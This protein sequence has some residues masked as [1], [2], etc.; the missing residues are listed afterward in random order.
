MSSRI[1]STNSAF[2]TWDGQ[3]PQSKLD[4]LRL[5]DDLVMMVKEGRHLDETEQQKAVCLLK[6]VTP[7]DHHP[8]RN[9]TSQLPTTDDDA[10]KTLLDSISILLTCSSRQVVYAAIS[11]LDEWIRWFPIEVR[12]WFV[13]TDQHIHLMNVLQPH[14]VTFE[15]NHS[16]HNALVSIMTRLLFFGATGGILHRSSVIQES[17]STICEIVFNKVLVPSQTYLRFLCQQRISHLSVEFVGRMLDLPIP[18]F[19]VGV[20]YPPAFT[21]LLSTSIFHF[22]T[23]NLFEFE[24]ERWIDYWVKKLQRF[25]LQWK[26]ENEVRPRWHALMGALRTEGLTDGL[27]QKWM[28]NANRFGGGCVRRN[29]LDLS[30]RSGVNARLFESLLI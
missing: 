30:N 19:D 18:L 29:A 26:D 7:S 25:S 20:F 13:K 11:L 16:F 21:I 28:N 2:E 17:T 1:K 12:F 4:S 23:R 24:D 14:A 27:E 22:F 5:F 15:D 3:I 9:I 6:E 8:A 10:R